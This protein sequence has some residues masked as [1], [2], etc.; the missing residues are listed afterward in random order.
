MKQQA[1]ELHGYAPDEIRVAGTPQ[2]D[3]LFP[4][5]HDHRR[6]RRSSASIG[7]DPSRKLVTL[8]TT[9]R[10]L[11]PH[12]DHV[13]RVL[14]RAMADGRLARAGAVAGPAASARRARRLPR[15]RRRCRTSS[16]RSRSGRRSRPATGWRSTSRPTASAISPTRCATATSSSTSRRRIAIEAAIFDTPV[17]NIVFDGEAPSEWAR[18]ARR[19]YRFTHYVNITRHDAVRVAEH[20]GAAGRAGRRATCDDPSL[21]REGRAARRARAVPVSRRPRRRARRAVRHRASLRGCRAAVR[22]SHTMCGIAGF[23][24]LSGGRPDAGRLARMVATLRHRGPDDRGHFLRSRRGA[25]R[26]AA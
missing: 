4:R 10:E 12:H 22:S 1:I 20:A 6:A 15:I 17:V 23:V 26:G 5:R 3:L 8:T 7:A 11:Y 24:S 16:S 2:W 19:Y 13:L 21:D 14:A 18:S 25:G 9:P